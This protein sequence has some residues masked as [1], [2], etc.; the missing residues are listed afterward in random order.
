[1]LSVASMF[2]LKWFWSFEFF[3]I[4]LL[5][6]SCAFMFFHFST[7]PTSNNKN[8]M[9]YH[10]L[11][12]LINNMEPD[13]HIN[14]LVRASL[15]VFSVCFHDNSSLEYIWIY[16]A[17]LN[18]Q[19]FPGPKY[20]QEKAHVLVVSCD[21][22][23]KISCVATKSACWLYHTGLAALENALNNDERGSN[24]ARNSVFD[25]HL[26]P[27]GRKWQ[28]KTVCNYFWSNPSI[29]LTISIAA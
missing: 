29:V 20:W 18:K 27:V 12:V 4:I 19:I 6:T 10:L 24:I 21:D 14:S 26:S 11:N 8:Y 13:H 7:L 22:E 25:C 17:D 15:S 28:S 23:A 3:R 2:A 9:F 5:I 16:A 1:M